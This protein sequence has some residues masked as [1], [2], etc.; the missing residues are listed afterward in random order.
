MAQAPGSD[1]PH[2]LRWYNHIKSYSADE[3][4][5]FPAGSGAYKSAGGA[6]AAPAKADDDDDVDLFASDEE[7]VSSWFLYLTQLKNTM[8]WTKEN[9]SKKIFSIINILNNLIKT[10]L[11]LRVNINVLTYNLT[12]IAWYVI[13]TPTKIIIVMSFIFW[14]F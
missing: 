5:K 1:N 7:D 10:K 8:S 6:P 9:V 4:Q 11:T 12:Q 14:F 3:R 2:A 13:H